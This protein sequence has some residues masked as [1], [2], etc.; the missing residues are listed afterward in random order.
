MW[1]VACLCLM[2]V[3]CGMDKDNFSKNENGPE[4]GK[5]AEPEHNYAVYMDGEYGY[6]PAVSENQT[7]NGQV[8]ATLFM[9]KY[10]GEKNGK[11]Q[12][13]SK[14]NDHVMA[15]MECQNPCE[16]I[17][18][19]HIINGMGVV[20]TEVM[21]AAPDSLGRI[22]FEDAIAGKLEPFVKEENGKRYS[23]WLE[24]KKMTRT[25]IH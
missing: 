25:I 1:K 13:F 6:Q 17:K 12:L 21:E 3:A 7:N 2:L 23:V 11:Y 20:K 19:N 14:Q 10:L 16:F 18:L 5:L 24:D 4:A 15:V 9:V 22:A 8:A